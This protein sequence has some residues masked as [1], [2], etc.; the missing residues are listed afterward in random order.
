MVGFNR[1]AK[2]FFQS[3]LRFEK[4][5]KCFAL[6]V[7]VISIHGFFVGKS[8]IT[9]FTPR[10]D[11]AEYFAVGI[12]V[13]EKG[14]FGLDGKPTAHREPVYPLVIAAFLPFVFSSDEIA[15]QPPIN[16]PYY[17]TKI[18]KV[19]I[20]N[21][22][23]LVALAMAT[24]IGARALTLSNFFGLLAAVVL[25]HT[26]PIVFGIDDFM[27]ENFSALILV[28]LGISL[29]YWSKKPTL[30]RSF[31][32]GIL[33]GIAAL[34]K[35]ACLYF[36][37]IAVAGMFLF[38][39]RSRRQKLR[40]C[41]I[42]MLLVTLSFVGVVG[43]WLYRNYVLFDRV[44]ITLHG[45]NVLANRAS[46]NDMTEREW[47][48]AFFVYGNH[49]WKKFGFEPAD[50]EN[51]NR[52]DGRGWPALHDAIK[53]NGGDPIK[54]DQELIRI[55]LRRILERPFKHLAVSIPLIY[56]LITIESPNLGRLLFAA[57]P[58]CM[59]FLLYCQRWSD[60]MMFLPGIYF[61]FFYP[62]T[63]H[64]VPRFYFAIVPFFI[65]ANAVVG[66]T[67]VS[68]FFRYINQKKLA[69]RT[70]VLPK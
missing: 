60:M 37:P 61:F 43:P 15:G 52:Y 64:S 8:H 31:N 41:T 30:F 27:K 35:A 49:D 25:L 51:F 17:F 55:S 65:I 63:S 26:G 56:R 28:C 14:M 7:F 1:M 23:I 13:F 53:R 66:K 22:L 69:A 11:S 50:V 21:V 47:L 62:L 44:F 34:T 3:L 70:A 36:F 54:G 10:S 33:I 16:E 39:W 57:V 68:V 58:L 20:I 9:G 40:Q 45:G 67:L 29:F 19:K 2:N 38:E 18:Q 46:F 42:S 12:H 59:I 5:R 24:F 48:A 4:S 6:C 32:I